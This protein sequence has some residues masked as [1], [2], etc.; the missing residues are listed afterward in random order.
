MSACASRVRWAMFLAWE[1]A[2]ACSIGRTD[3]TWKGGRFL[4]L[5]LTR[6]SRA[7]PPWERDAHTL[8]SS[9]EKVALNRHICV[10][11][12][13]GRASTM[14]AAFAGTCDIGTDELDDSDSIRSWILVWRM[15]FSSVSDG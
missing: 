11:A 8:G 14:V 12:S 13:G 7:S 1:A 10:T 5:S 6:A 2:K 9:T 4:Y 3:P 15:C